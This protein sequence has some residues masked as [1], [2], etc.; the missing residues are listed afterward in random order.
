M[1]LMYPVT[2]AK[3]NNR[4][5]KRHSQTSALRFHLHAYHYINNCQLNIEMAIFRFAGLFSWDGLLRMHSFGV[6]WIRISDPRSVWIMVH[7]KNRRIH[8]HDHGLTSSFEFAPW[9]RQ[10]LDHWSWSRSPQR[11]ARFMCYTLNKVFFFLYVWVNWSICIV[12]L[13]VGLW[14][15]R[16]Y[17]CQCI[18]HY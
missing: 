3:L 2:F 11:N 13:S 7:Q 6:I 1:H 12:R 18:F 10:I 8:S 9:S 15:T 14:V 16:I 4:K 5:E 17:W